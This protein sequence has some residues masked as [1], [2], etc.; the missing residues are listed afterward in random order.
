MV[1]SLADRIF[2]L[3]A[4]LALELFWQAL[5]ELL[6]VAVDDEEELRKAEPGFEEKER[7]ARIFLRR[8]LI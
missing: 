7:A 5:L 8:T 2:Q 4:V 3:S 6:S 1:R